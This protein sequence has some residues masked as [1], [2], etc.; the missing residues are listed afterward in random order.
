[1]FDIFAVLRSIDGCDHLVQLNTD[2][3]GR[4]RVKG[5][6]FRQAVQVARGAIPVLPFP[7]VHGELDGMAVRTLKRFILVEQGLHVVFAGGYI[8][9]ALEGV[10]K[11][12]AVEGSRF[13][14]RP[15]VHID[16]KNQ[17]GIGPVANLKSGL[18]VIV[19]GEQE[20]EAAVL[21]AVVF[22]IVGDGEVGRARRNFIFTRGAAVQGQ[23]A[24][25]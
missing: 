11:G 24:K 23:G 14:R 12:G 21:Q 5:D 16:T 22:S 19:F 13:T 9:K 4:Y 2:G 1:M 18:S 15:A 6:P 3:V 20:Q 17:L 25:K 10:A 7:A 8:S